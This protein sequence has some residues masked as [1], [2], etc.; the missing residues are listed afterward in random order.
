MRVGIPETGR[1][2]RAE[3]RP[4]SS[5]ERLRLRAPSMLFLP[6]WRGRSC[7]VSSSASSD[8]RG[9]KE[10]G[11]FLSSSGAP[12]RRAW[13]TRETLSNCLYISVEGEGQGHA[14]I[15]QQRAAFQRS[16]RDLEL[17][18]RSARMAQ[19]AQMPVTHG[20]PCLAPRCRRFPFDRR[21]NSAQWFGPRRKARRRS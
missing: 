12:A 11:E 4:V 9:A 3:Y 18:A 10:Q 20:S 19:R 14:S 13:A 1:R 8:C 16:K 15:I 7:R 6:P 21:Q 2:G 5:R 17:S